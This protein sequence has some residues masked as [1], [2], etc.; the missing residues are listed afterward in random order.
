VRG[1]IEH[2]LLQ[3]RLAEAETRFGAEALAA[4]D[5][6]VRE[7]RLAALAPPGPPARDQPEPPPAAPGVQ[8]P[9]P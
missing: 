4:A 2:M 9:A 6:E 1:G 3:R 5:I 7:D 8:E